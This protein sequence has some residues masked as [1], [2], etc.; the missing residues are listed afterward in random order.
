MIRIIKINIEWIIIALPHPK[1][2][3]LAAALRYRIPKNI[4]IKSV[5]DYL[6]VIS[7]TFKCFI[8]II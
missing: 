3:L 7:I 1:S 4:I 8:S 2:E 6:G 5:I